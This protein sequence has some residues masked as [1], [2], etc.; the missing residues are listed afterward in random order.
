MNAHVQLSV[1][2]R[3]GS[4]PQQHGGNGAATSEVPTDQHWE[5]SGVWKPRGRSSPNPEIS[6]HGASRHRH[7]EWTRTTKTAPAQ[8]LPRSP[9]T[10]RAARDQPGAGNSSLGQGDWLPCFPGWDC[11]SAFLGCSCELLRLS[12]NYKSLGIASP[13]LSWDSAPTKQRW[14]SANPGSS[15]RVR[16]AQDPMHNWQDLHQPLELFLFSAKITVFL[17]KPLFKQHFFY[18][19]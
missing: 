8:S 5:I 15:S 6:G 4:A 10:P 18:L 3:A 13:G 14:L 7:T 9:E 11:C 12:T 17:Q 16:G 2:A 19:C 1:A